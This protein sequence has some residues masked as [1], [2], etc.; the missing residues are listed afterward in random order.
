MWIPGSSAESPRTLVSPG[1]PGSGPELPAAPSCSGRGTDPT[2]SP[3]R[4]L[5][6]P[7]LPRTDGHAR[8]RFRAPGDFGAFAAAGRACPAGSPAPLALGPDSRPPS[9]DSW[10]APEPDVWAG[11]AGR[12]RGRAVNY[13]LP[14]LSG[15]HRTPG[16]PRPGRSKPALVRDVPATAPGQPPGRGGGDPV[17]SWTGG[18]PGPPSSCEAGWRSRQQVARRPPRDSRRPRAGRA[19]PSPHRN[20]P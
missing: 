1:S 19:P 6:A 18:P 20:G 13:R 7:Y 16:C 10:L 5:S 17:K 15:Q 14:G 11:P 9:L 3:A 4:W 2:A 12:G 8:C